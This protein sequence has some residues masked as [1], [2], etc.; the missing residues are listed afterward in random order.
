M[1]RMTRPWSRNKKSQAHAHQQPAGHAPAA[2][3]L[4]GV[5]RAQGHPARVRGEPHGA[6]PG[7]RNHVF[8]FYILVFSN[9]IFV[10]MK[11]VI[12]V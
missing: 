10:I 8:L 9:F 4:R 1:V 3:L 12:I 7:A 5:Q 2:G 6:H 11:D